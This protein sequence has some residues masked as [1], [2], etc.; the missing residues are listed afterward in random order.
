MK[1]SD[2]LAGRPPM[3]LQKD[4]SGLHLMMNQCYCAVQCVLFTDLEKQE[5]MAVKSAASL[6]DRRLVSCS[7]LPFSIS[8]GMYN[9]VSRVSPS[10]ARFLLPST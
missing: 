4:L 5:R 10:P 3:G 7:K 9:A 8:C 1:A 2:G 6:K